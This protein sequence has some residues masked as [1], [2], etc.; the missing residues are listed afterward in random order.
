MSPAA[1]EWFILYGIPRVAA[2]EENDDSIFEKSTNMS[3][4]FK[5]AP[6]PSYIT[7]ASNVDMSAGTMLHDPSIAAVDSCG[8]I[9]LCGYTVIGS[10]YYLCDPWIRRTLGI[11]P[12]D[13]IQCPH[14]VGLI[15]NRSDNH[16]IVAELNPWRLE[17]RSP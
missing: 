3:F 11:L 16:L 9:L 17:D 4:T 7:V 2:K 12:H 5:K 13:G 1:A 6:L 10:S 14:S 8:V 15:R